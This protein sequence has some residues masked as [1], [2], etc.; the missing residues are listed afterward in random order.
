MS[1]SSAERNCIDCGI[2]T[3]IYIT[4]DSGKI[5]CRECNAINMFIDDLGQSKS[6]SKSKPKSK[7]KPKPVP[8][9]PKSKSK[10]T[11]HS[12]FCRKCQKSFTAKTCK[13]GFKN[14]LMR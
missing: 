7:P 14:P 12:V 9:E 8:A 13:C 1:L 5:F 11:E 6:K 4:T 3:R 10:S 2:K